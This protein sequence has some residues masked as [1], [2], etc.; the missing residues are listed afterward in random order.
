M[1]REMKAEPVNERKRHKRAKVKREKRCGDDDDGERNKDA[2]R[3]QKGGSRSNSRRRRRRSRSR[4]S[5][6]S[7]SSSSLSESALYRKFKPYTKVQLVNLVRKAELNG[8]TGQVVHPSTAV[9]PCPPG[10][11]LVRLETGREIAVKPPNLTPLRAFHV[12]PQQAPQSQEERLQQ[13]LSQIKMNVDN[14]MERTMALRDG[15]G[16]GMLLDS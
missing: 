7:S 10:C 2:R 4:S 3:Q 16:S 6:S 9:S 5:S 12:G 14:V 13:V 1:K 8:M 11:I 15:D